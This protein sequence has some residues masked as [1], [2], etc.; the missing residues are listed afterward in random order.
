VLCDTTLR[1]AC[2]IRAPATTHGFDQSQRLVP[3]TLLSVVQRADKVRNYYVKAPAD[4]FVA[5][6]GDYMLF[7][8]SSSGVPSIAQW[9][10]VGSVEDGQFD[11]TNPADISL[12]CEFISCSA[13]DDITWS[14]S[15]DDGTSGTALD[16]EIRY[17]WSPITS[18]NFSSCDLFANLPIPALPGT[19]H[20]V[21]GF[22]GLSTNTTLYVAGRV[23]D[24]AGH[25][26]SLSY[27]QFTTMGSCG[28]GG[29]GESVRR[30]RDGRGA[31]GTDGRRLGLKARAFAP[32]TSL[33]GSDS[34]M[35]LVGEFSRGSESRW[36]LT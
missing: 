17:S 23:K 1:F 20:T 2:L 36:Q 10:R 11:T 28:G 27:S 12:T 7:V 32:P 15:G 26:S 14:S 30:S 8:S 19:K 29:M 24:K 34:P 25:L 9:V 31:D 35:R 16:F 18:S 6:P 33:V 4:S 5:P 3:L 13:I 22:S 21:A